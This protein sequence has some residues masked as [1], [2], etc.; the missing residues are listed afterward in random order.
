MYSKDLHVYPKG[1]VPVKLILKRQD[2]VT[3]R[4]GTYVRD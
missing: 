1:P 4:F 3:C 2:V